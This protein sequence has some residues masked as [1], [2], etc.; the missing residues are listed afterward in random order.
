MECRVRI[1][2][3]PGSQTSNVEW[4]NAAPLILVQ[5]TRTKVLATVAR[6]RQSPGKKVG[7][8]TATG[9]WLCEQHSWTEIDSSGSKAH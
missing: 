7:K 6:P 9:A 2:A 1:L 3:I 4:W 5:T 8:D